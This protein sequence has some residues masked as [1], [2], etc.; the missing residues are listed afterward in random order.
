MA[1][2]PETKQCTHHLVLIPVPSISWTHE[3]ACTSMG[4]CSGG[5]CI[6]LLLVK[7]QY[8]TE[9]VW[10]SISTGLFLLSFL[11]QYSTNHIASIPP[12]NPILPTTIPAIGPGSKLAVGGVG[13]VVEVCNTPD[14][15]VAKPKFVMGLATVENTVAVSVVL[16]IDCSAKLMPVDV[17]CT[18]TTNEDHAGHV[19]P[20]VHIAL[21]LLSHGVAYVQSLEVLGSVPV[22]QAFGQLGDCHVGSVHAPRYKAPPLGPPGH[23]QRPFGW[24]ISDPL[25]LQQEEKVSLVQGT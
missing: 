5:F 6:G 23:Q 11:L 20:K 7:P 3:F 21:P 4:G 14:P 18:E 24:Q 22:L 8:A 12:I 15:P 25:G 17:R 9:E 2:H 10:L 13:E 19:A 1:R 16:R